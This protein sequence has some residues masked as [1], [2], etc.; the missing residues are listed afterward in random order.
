VKAYA[1]VIVFRE[2]SSDKPARL[3]VDFV[4]LGDAK[5]AAQVERMSFKEL[6]A[7]SAAQPYTIPRAVI[8]VVVARSVAEIRE[9]DKKR[10]ARLKKRAKLL[11]K[12]KATWFGKNSGYYPINAKRDSQGRL[13][14]SQLDEKG[15]QIG[16]EP[17]ARAT[18][19]RLRKSRESAQR[20]AHRK[21]TR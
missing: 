17:L 7:V 10:V 14:W 15:K 13:I 2:A 11:K 12:H 1:I 6:T 3:E 5:T 4:H 21:G 19:K 8:S 18:L 9:S 20:V 16:T